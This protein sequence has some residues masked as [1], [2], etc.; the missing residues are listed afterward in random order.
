[1]IA[2]IWK[3][4]AILATI[5]VFALV[6]GYDRVSTDQTPSP[7]TVQMPDETSG[8][9]IFRETAPVDSTQIDYVTAPMASELDYSK[10]SVI[11]PEG[12]NPDTTPVVLIDGVWIPEESPE[13]GYPTG[14]ADNSPTYSDGWLLQVNDTSG[15]ILW[16]S[17]DDRQDSDS[18]IELGS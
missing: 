2:K 6:N 13:G 8:R 7:V 16:L 4:A 18:D 9:N 15:E 10:E 1:M 11:V 5:L 17:P 14:W 12:Q 3:M